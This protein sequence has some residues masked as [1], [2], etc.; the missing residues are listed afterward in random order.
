MEFEYR[1]V[2]A[3]DA[4]IDIEDIGQC[5]L[6]LMDT[7][8]QSYYLIVRTLMGISTVFEYGPILVGETVL[9]K[10]VVCKISKVE[11]SIPKIKKI[12][13]LFILDNEKGQKK[14]EF[15]RELSIDEALSNCI[16]IIDY[17]R[18]HENMIEAIEKE[19]GDKE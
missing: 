12:I 9:P 7:L 5:C 18:Q 13:S 11:F 19:Y 4:T 1:P 8:G 6:E 3:F 17:M 15:V 10:F 16:D 14:T 2:K